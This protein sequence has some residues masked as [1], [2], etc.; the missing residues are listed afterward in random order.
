M[1]AWVC[2]FDFACG[3]FLRVGGR[4]PCHV[5]CGGHVIKSGHCLENTI[6]VKHN[7]NCNTRIS[8][9]Y[10]N[11][12]TKIDGFKMICFNC[13]EEC[14]PAKESSNIKKEY[15]AFLESNQS[16]MQ[17]FRDGPC[18]HFGLKFNVTESNEN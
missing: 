17:C 18:P 7:I 10:Y 16:H 1:C 6:F 8:A 5:S 3:S 13:I 14:Q 9:S 11:M 2:T 4:C 15:Q 12:G